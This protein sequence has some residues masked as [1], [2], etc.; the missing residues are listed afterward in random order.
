SD[1]LMCEL[2]SRSVRI[3]AS[4]VS[5]DERESGQRALLNFGHTVGHA[6]EVA[7]GFGSLLHGEA[8]ALGM[9]AASRVSA[10]LGGDPNLE[11]RL[12]RLLRQLAL[13]TDI[14]RYLKEEVLAHMHTDKKRSGNKIGFV[15]VDRVGVARVEPLDSKEIRDL[16]RKSSI[17]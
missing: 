16:L 8:V 14:D 5:G 2:V 12:V 1:A 10:R 15:V 4:I 7:T 11:N 13:P 6:I 3:K 9:L 17:S